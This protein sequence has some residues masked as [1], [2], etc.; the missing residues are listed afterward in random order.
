M[1]MKSQIKKIGDTLVISVDGRLNF[2]NQDELIKSLKQ[3]SAQ[4]F[5]KRKTDSAAIKILFDIS[6]L[7]FAGS[8]GISYFV[9][10]MKEFGE[11]MNL[12]PQIL[13]ASKDFEL[14][15]KAFDTERTLEFVEKFDVENTDSPSRFN[16]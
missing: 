1:K 13:G 9:Q 2:D 12:K 5:Q 15:I 7:E 4:Q 3:I 11:D 16:N 6:A 10:N 14:V 8:A